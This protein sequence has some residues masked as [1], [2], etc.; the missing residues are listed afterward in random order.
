M[1]QKC[2]I[3]VLF[4][5]F[6]LFSFC[7]DY[8]FA[9][10][11]AP[12]Q[13]GILYWSMNIPGQVAM[14]KGLEAEAARINKEAKL[15]GKRGVELVVKVAG[16][17]E[18]GISNQITQMGELLDLKPDLLIV[19]PTDNVA[20]SS[21]LIRANKEKIPVV[22][23]DQYI[24]KGKL[25]AYRTSNNYQAG[26]LGGE[27]ISSRFNVEYEIKL[28]LVDYPYVSS[29][30]ERLNG[31]L[32]GLSATGQK[33]KILDSYQAV[34]PLSG[35][36]VALKILED[37]PEKG[38]IDVIFTVNDGGGLPIVEELS[39]AGR[40]EIQHATVD[41]DPSSI[42]NILEKKLTVIDS[43]QFCG[44]L[45]SETMKVAYKILLGEKVFYHA[46]IPVFPVT[47]ETFA[48]YPGWMG[49]IPESFVKPWKSL[50]NE[51]KG[52]L[53]VIKP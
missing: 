3:K 4:F 20:L 45:G 2:K 32:D 36:K 43:A 5:A 1:R 40:N 26:W 17:G 14:R 10:V 44:P 19:Q 46:L 12:Y 15:A 39:K 18:D 47:V 38:S 21:M 13:I 11:L 41:G 53:E 48:Q 25:A 6:L 29:T 52:S 27:F 37:F 9:D 30:V 8:L 49:P 50:S 31:F 33:Y 28:I 34:E 23:Y 24:S 16:D 7:S 51:W 42:K 35:R 22:A